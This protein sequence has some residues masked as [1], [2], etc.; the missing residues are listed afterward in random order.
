M[1]NNLTKKIGILSILS[2]VLCATIGQGIAKADIPGHHPYYLHA[3]SDLRKAEQLLQLPDE[4]NVKQQE[5]I[6]AR[7]VHAAIWEIDNAAV[8][9][10]KDVDDNPHIDTS[11][12]HHGRFNEIERLLQSAKHDISLEE[13]NNA[14]RLWRHRANVHLDRAEYHVNIAAERDRIDDHRY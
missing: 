1:N 4:G 13:N 8:L 2:T 12:R 14:A 7:E 3:R 10:R 5:N 6:A 11:L 9:D